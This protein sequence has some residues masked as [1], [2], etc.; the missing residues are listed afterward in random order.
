MLLIV[1]SIA[2]KLNIDET[3]VLIDKLLTFFLYL[4]LI[5]PSR[6]GWFAQQSTSNR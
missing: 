4:K 3:L 5:T 2:Y 1:V 6:V